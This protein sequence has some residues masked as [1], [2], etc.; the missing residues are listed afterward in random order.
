MKFFA[1]HSRWLSGPRTE[2]LPGLRP[3]LERR[4]VAA[5]ADATL[6][7]ATLDDVRMM[8]GLYDNEVMTA[9]IRLLD[10][11]LARADRSLMRLAI[12]SAF[13]V[14]T[15]IRI[16]AHRLRLVTSLAKCSAWLGDGQLVAERVVDELRTVPA[17]TH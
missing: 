12:A 5:A 10:S 2:L 7:V 16:I 4:V 6:L 15:R 8:P 13:L 1:N 3:A 11:A 14:S 17:L 9:A